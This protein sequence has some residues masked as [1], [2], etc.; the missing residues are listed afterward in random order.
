MTDLPS[1]PD[2][3]TL[4]EAQ[5]ADAQP[6]PPAG[7]SVDAPGESGL[8]GTARSIASGF[9][10][11][12]SAGMQGTSLSGNV[13]GA[14]TTFDATTS[15]DCGPGITV[16]GVTVLGPTAAAVSLQIAQLASIG[17]R[18]VTATTGSQ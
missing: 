1:V 16:T 10:Q 7:Y 11:N 15:L 3:Y 14:Y 6:A 18:T 17:S 2:G 5:P 4:D 12:L 13:L 8:L 9:A